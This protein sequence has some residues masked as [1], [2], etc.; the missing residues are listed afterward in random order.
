MWNWRKIKTKKIKLAQTTPT[1]HTKMFV[2]NARTS[3]ITESYFF[4]IILG[5]I[6]VEKNPTNSL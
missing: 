1:I 4:A 5:G 2:T 6:L 3:L